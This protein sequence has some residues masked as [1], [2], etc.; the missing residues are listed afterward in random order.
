MRTLIRP[1][2]RRA[3]ACPHALGFR[4]PGARPP[5][6]RKL[7]ARAAQTVC[8]QSQTAFNHCISN[9][10]C[11]LPQHCLLPPHSGHRSDT[12]RTLRIAGP[13]HHSI[14]IVTACILY[15]CLSR[16]RPQIIVCHIVIA[17]DRYFHIVVAL[18]P[19]SALVLRAAFAPRYCPLPVISTSF[20]SITQHITTLT[21]CKSLVM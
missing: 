19:S 4:H 6:L 20:S 14:A 15:H 5:S 9:K 11:V 2:R 13:L 12:P 16:Y 17:P 3:H 8:L 21:A 10:T 7:A 1:S 18:R